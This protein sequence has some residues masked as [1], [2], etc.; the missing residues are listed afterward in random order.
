MNG[1]CLEIHLMNNIKSNKILIILLLAFAM[2]SIFIVWYFGSDLEILTGNLRKWIATIFIILLFFICVIYS[3]FIDYLFICNEKKSLITNSIEYFEDLPK[4][5]RYQYGMLWRRRVRKCLVLGSTADTDLVLPDLIAQRFQLNERTLMMYAGDISDAPNNSWLKAMKKTF[6]RMVL[7]RRKPI[8]AMIWVQPANYLTLNR[9]QQAELELAIKNIQLYHQTLGWK[10]PLYL[11]STQIS[12]WSQ[13]DRTEQSVGLLFNDLKISNLTTIDAAIDKLAT[14]CS[15]TGMQ[16]VMVDTRYAFLLQ[17]SQNLVQQDKAR[18]K[19]WLT[20]WLAF[21]HVPTLRGLFFTPVSQ[22][23]DKETE[24]IK[25]LYVPSHHLTLTP[26]WQ[27]I[28][29]DAMK[30]SGRKVGIAWGTLCCSLI[31]L[32]MVVMSTGMVISYYQNKTLIAYSTELVNNVNNTVDAP[33]GERLNAQYHLQQQMGQLIYREQG[34]SPIDYRFGLNHNHELLNALWPHYI[35]ANT[36]NI[37]QPFFAWQT[38]YLTRLTA[39]SPNDPNRSKMVQSSYDVLKAYLMLSTP[40]KIDA[41]YLSDFATRI[42]N[43]PAGITITEWQK[44]MPEL[45]TFWGQAIQLKPELALPPSKQLIKD[46]RQILINQ[47]GVQNAENTIYQA[48]LQRASQNSANLTLATLLGDIDGRLLFNST[49]ELPG[50][51]TRK[52]WENFI[53]NEIAS[54]ARSRQE[55]I[56]WVLSDGSQSAISSSISPDTLRQHLTERYFNDYSAAWLLFLNNIQWRQADN[57]ADVIEQLTLMSDMRQSPLVALMNVIKYQAEVAYTGG[58]ISDNL[59]RSAQDLIKDKN[60]ANLNVKSEASGPLTPTF[61]A[62]LNLMNNE[63][64]NGLSLQTYLLRVTQVRLKLQNITSSANP[65]VMAKLLAKSVFQGTSVDLTETRDYGNLIAA[66]L[67]DE[68]SGFGYNLFQLPLEQAWQVVLTPAANSFND[69]WQQQIVYEWER[70]FAGRYPFKNTDSDASLAELARFLRPDAGVIDKFIASELAGVLEKQG[71]KWV[72]N[73][74]NA[75]GLNFS[76]KFIETL[77]LFNEL[78]HQIISSGDTK[79]AFDIMPRSGNNIVRSELV[80]DKQ[81]VNYF[82]Q[83]PIWN[84]VSWPGEEYSPYAQLSWSSDESG[85]RLYDYYAGDWAWIRL[86]ES[87]TIRQIDSSRYEV[88][89]LVPNDGKL[90]YILR[91]QSGEGPIALLKLRNFTLPKQVFDVAHQKDESMKITL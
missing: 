51:F 25:A 13:A 31:L 70:A 1:V 19:K 73:P 56:D 57:I 75:Q 18:I 86:L 16:Q 85:L 23:D 15:E 9:R 83:M 2:L 80:I 26:T 4:R 35:A 30:Q 21:P 27:F 44:F 79:I 88:I 74:V 59:I 34:Y 55:Q 60:P 46:V 65:Q 58:G 12:D 81:K 40:D 61:G 29:D 82:N 22:H 45:I 78:S 32:G 42:W 24:A 84:R 54:A 90:K 10:V 6:G 87:A 3:E 91:S 49:D 77:N 39:M 11:V 14:Q 20:S 72:I 67:G 50:V 33:Y 76:P 37:G 41:H 43:V 48:I 52:A 64:S 36:N 63:N 71:E 68:W 66:N 89:W 8:D 7:L 28:S 47:I 17:L 62:V 69:T 38:N 5:L 53:K